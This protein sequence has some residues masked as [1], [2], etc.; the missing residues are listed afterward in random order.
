MNDEVYDME[1]QL[2]R[3]EDDITGVLWTVWL[4]CTRV[5]YRM[6][7][8]FVFYVVIA[9]WWMA[10]LFIAVLLITAFW[11]LKTPTFPLLTFMGLKRANHKHHK[12]Q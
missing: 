8:L 10:A 9:P 7:D 12:H 3:P 5:G 1:I 11:L 6:K 2:P 4:M